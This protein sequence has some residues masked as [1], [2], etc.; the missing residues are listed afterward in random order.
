MLFS[1]NC[2]KQKFYVGVAWNSFNLKNACFRKPDKYN[3]QR[4]EC[5]PYCKM[6]GIKKVLRERENKGKKS[7]SYYVYNKEQYKRIGK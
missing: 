2:V 7:N 3:N 6:K 4:R 1:S 5:K